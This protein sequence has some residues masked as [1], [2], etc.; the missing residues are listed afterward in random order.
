MGTFYAGPL[1]IC[2]VAM[3][4][5]LPGD[6]MHQQATSIS[7]SVGMTKGIGWKASLLHRA[8]AILGSIDLLC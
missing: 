6:T 2:M 3:S 7:K 1:T 5:K 8:L 4:F